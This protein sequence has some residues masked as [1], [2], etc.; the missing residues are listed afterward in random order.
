MRHV[1]QGLEAKALEELLATR[2]R[3]DLLEQEA[4]QCKK[5]LKAVI[6]EEWNR[7]HFL[8]GVLR[9]SVSEQ[10]ALPGM[11]SSLVERSRKIG[12]V[13]RALIEAVERITGEAAEVE[14]R[15][16]EQEAADVLREAR[17]APGAEVAAAVQRFKDA[18][19]D[20]TEVSVGI[21]GGEMH[22]IKGKR[23]RKA[24]PAEPAP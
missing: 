23:G 16:E 12:Q 19:P 18:I 21:N 17:R 20:D 24:P 8:L 7:E 3:I 9:G 2:S 1:S 10:V 6:A 22:T 14:E 5:G 11:E 15:D 4:E 13:L